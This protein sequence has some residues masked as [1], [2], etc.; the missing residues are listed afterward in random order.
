MAISTPTRVFIVLFLIWLVAGAIMSFSMTP[1]MALG[2]KQRYK[3][4]PYQVYQ[5]V[6]ACTAAIGVLV[7]VYFD[8]NKV[9]PPTELHE[10]STKVDPLM[11]TDAT[12]ELQ[13]ALIIPDYPGTY[14]PRQTL[15]SYLRF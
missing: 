8:Y 3:V 10:C 5:I 11:A 2:F 6:G 7:R 15:P 13:E 9:D 1:D 4:D 14:V 12:E